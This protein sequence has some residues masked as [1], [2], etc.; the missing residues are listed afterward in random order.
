MSCRM[1]RTRRK[2]FYIYAS[3]SLRETEPQESEAPLID[4]KMPRD[5]DFNLPVFVM[6]VY[7]L[8]EFYYII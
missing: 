4:E 7:V 1:S 3:L 6:K 2:T 5:L 8:Y